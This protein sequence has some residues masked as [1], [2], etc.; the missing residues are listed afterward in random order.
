MAPTPASL[1]SAPP[2]AGTTLIIRNA[3]VVTMAKDGAVPSGPARGEAMGEL[4]AVERADVYI[5][6]ARI[7]EVRP[8]V[9]PKGA[10]SAKPSGAGG[11]D[12]K[13]PAGG[14]IEEIDA[15]G[16]ALVPGLVDC[17]TH[18]CWAGSRLDEWDQRRRG[19]A[20]LTILKRGGGIMATVRAV[21][22]ASMESLAQGL[23]A[24]A[25]KML[26]LGST[27]IE[28]KSGYGLTTESEL[29]M[30]RAIALAQKSFPGLLVPTA[31]VGHAI[32]EEQAGFVGRVTRETLP[33]VAGEFP[34]ITVDAYCEKGAWSV[35]QCVKLFSRARELGLGVRVHADQFNSLGM[36][37]AALHLDARSVDH[38]EAT[39]KEDLTLLAGSAGAGVM[40]PAC[41]FHTGERYARGRSFV[42]QGGA[43]AIASNCNPGSAPCGSMAMVIA[44]GVRHL[45]LSPQEA[46]CAATRNPAWVLGLSDRGWIGRGARAD[47]LLLE[48]DDERALGFEFGTS[49]IAQVIVAGQRAEKFL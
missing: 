5:A 19:V 29:K 23:L 32:D 35:E 15:G 40:L 14:L 39:T 49:P 7:A 18:A 28:V 20:Y 30:L 13:A 31:L 41:G 27:T 45:G 26:L 47:M 38:L 46:L 4:H 17:H 34:G 37:Q 9:A 22:E 3:R 42:G 2:P 6:G 24:R 21:R 44:L 12:A 48:G 33:A 36:V 25:R 8:L 10:R 11:G 1:R 43:L 16:R